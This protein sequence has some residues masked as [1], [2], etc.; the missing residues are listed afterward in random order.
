M[1]VVIPMAGK[2]SRFAKNGYDKPKFMLSID[3]ISLL[4][5][6][7][8]SLPLSIAEKII[9]IALQEHENEWN[10]SE[11]IKNKYPDNNLEF[12]FLSETTRGQ[13][14]TVL[15]A[16]D[17]I[18]NDE[19]LL[20]Y[21]IDTFFDSATLKSNLLKKDCDGYLG[22]FYDENDKW[23]FAKTDEDGFVIKTTEKVPI[24]TNA[25]TGMYHFNLGSDFVRVAEEAINNND[26]VKNEFYI[27][28]LYNSLIKEGKKFK[29][30]LV[31]DFVALGTPED[32]E[33]A[34]S[35]K[36]NNLNSCKS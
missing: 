20:I 25:L 15:A 9:F 34:K 35:K 32:F 12:V 14:E 8:N 11:F 4:E 27:A 3:G 2:G 7:V 24:S 33:Y 19:E 16:K 36:R 10:I 1:N 17:Y 23:S 26:L 29:L 5:Y 30:D 31:T 28:P 21:N 22:A 13:S 18:N 6:S